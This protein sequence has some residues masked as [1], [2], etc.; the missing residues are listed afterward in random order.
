[1]RK[2]IQSKKNEN[3]DLMTDIEEIKK[4]KKIPYMPMMWKYKL[5]RSYK[6]SQ[7]KYRNI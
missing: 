6:T 3:K 4:H 5:S 7:R 1:M 2:Q